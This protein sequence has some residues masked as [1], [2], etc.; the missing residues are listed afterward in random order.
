MA[1]PG[2]QRLTK[3]RTGRTLLKDQRAE[4]LAKSNESHAE[5]A[6]FVFHKYN[7]KHGGLDLF[8][9]F[10]ELG[11]S[12]GRQNR[13]NEEMREW[14][15]REFKRAKEGR[16]SKEN[17]DTLSVRRAPSLRAWPRRPACRAAPRGRPHQ[18]PV[19]PAHT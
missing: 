17:S 4:L 18:P 6:T 12:N 19:Q 2:G 8:R 16:S 15:R 9:C 14:V 1:S 11:F 10:N 13:T 3:Q 7:S 5:E